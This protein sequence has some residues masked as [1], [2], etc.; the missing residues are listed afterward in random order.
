VRRS[1]APPLISIYVGASED[2]TLLFGFMTAGWNF[3]YIFLTCFIA[4]NDFED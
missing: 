1:D 4:S 3:R 2:S